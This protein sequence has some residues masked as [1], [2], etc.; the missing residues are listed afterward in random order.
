MIV[1]KKCRLK[2]GD[3]FWKGLSLAADFERNLYL[4]KA[5]DVV[6]ISVVNI[7]INFLSFAPDDA[8]HTS[9]QVTKG[10]PITN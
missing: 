1:M 5:D 9:S 7:S 4:P 2:D 3:A 6:L 8:P 10:N